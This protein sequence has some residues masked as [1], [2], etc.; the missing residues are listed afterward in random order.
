M[1]TTMIRDSWI[2]TAAGRICVV[3]FAAAAVAGS[4]C[5]RGDTSE[6]GGE[7]GISVETVVVEVGQVSPTLDYSGTV[8]PWREASVGAMMS[9]QIRRFHVEAGDRVGEGELMVEMAGEQLTQTEARFVAVKKDWERVTRLFEKGAVTRQALDQAEAG[10]QAAKASYELVLGS[11]QIR[12]P[13]PGV[14][15][16]TY[17]EEGEVFVLMPG[18]GTSSP[19]VVELVQMDTV[20]VHVDVAERHLALVR[21]GI[22]AVLTADGRPGRTFQGRVRLVEPSLSALTRSSRAE[23]AVPNPGEVLLPGMFAH[24]TLELRPQETV[25]I[26]SRAVAQQEGTGTYYA[27]V[28]DGGVAV[29]RELQ[30]GQMYGEHYEVLAG[31][32]GGEHAVTSGKFGLADGASVTVRSEGGER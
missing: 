8:E 9:G 6:S 18:G 25:L 23:I 12:A 14:V 3:V 27:M 24:V 13:F 28:V 31:L 21:P 15:T 11:T 1:E 30:L 22:R 7:V 5:G 20:K 4:G 29:R 16:A 2:R 17:L 10:Y 19:A 32:A 26:P